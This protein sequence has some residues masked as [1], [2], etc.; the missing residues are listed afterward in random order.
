VPE[1]APQCPETKKPNPGPPT[2]VLSR[3]SR[4]DRRILRYRNALG[5]ALIQ[6]MQ[7]QPF[8]AITVQQ[9]LDRADVSRV[10]FYALL[11]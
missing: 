7:E 3:V 11:P 5:D 2:Q 1:C 6:L 10:T 9:V 8:D 4:P